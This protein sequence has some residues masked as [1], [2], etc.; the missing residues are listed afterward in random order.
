MGPKNIIAQSSRNIAQFTSQGSTTTSAAIGGVMTRG[1]VKVTA[2][3][4]KEQATVTAAS[5]SRKIT[6]GDF[7]VAKEVTQITYHALKQKYMVGFNMP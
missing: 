1:M 6:N 7:N 4:A 2:T 3:W 5:Q